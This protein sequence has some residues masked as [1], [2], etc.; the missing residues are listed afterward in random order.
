MREKSETSYLISSL[1]LI[2]IVGFFLTLRGVFLPHLAEDLHVSDTVLGFYFS[3]V[4]LGY[5]LANIITP[6][7]LRRNSAFFTSCIG[8]ILFVFSVITLV[9]PNLLPLLPAGLILY[10]LSLSMFNLLG[11]SVLSSL[12][13]ET[14]IR[15]FNALHV[16]YGVGTLLSPLV[17]AVLNNS[18]TLSLS[19]RS[20]LGYICLFMPVAFILLFFLKFARFRRTEI[21]EISLR[22]FKGLWRNKLSVNFLFFALL[23]GGLELGL[24]SWIPRYL[25]SARGFTPGTA[26]LFLSLFCAFL[27]GGRILGFLFVER[28]GRLRS[29]RIAVWA[30]MINVLLMAVPL[31]PFSFFV[32]LLG[33]TIAV[34]FP[35]ASAIITLACPESASVILSSTFF[36]CG[37]GFF[38]FPGLIGTIAEIIGP[39]GSFELISIILTFFVLLTI[40]ILIK[41]IKNSNNLID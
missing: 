1:I 38:I 39:G 2:F 5:I 21:D 24:S 31:R 28:L 41:N 7:I 23:Y 14:R 29:L 11:N 10:G 26:A 13:R 35:T 40:N 12:S 16:C 27:T 20:S 25:V 34:I 6:L 37:C 36:L 8:G 17:F 4:A 15:N 30:T 18:E 22:T 33:L 3:L 19:W 9:V 32:P